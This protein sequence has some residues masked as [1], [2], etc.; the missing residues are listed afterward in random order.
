MK[1]KLIFIA[2][3]IVLMIVLLI[4]FKDELTLNEF[5]LTLAGSGGYL[6]AVWKWF[7]EVEVKQ[8]FEKQIG[9]KYS[10]FKQKS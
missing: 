5:V 7:N 3:V 1:K 9:I 2:I 4:F 8:E 6:I 10:T